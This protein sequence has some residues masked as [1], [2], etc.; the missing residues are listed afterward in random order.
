MSIESIY[1]W[2][3]NNPTTTFFILIPISMIVFAVSRSFIGK[4]LV[5][6]SER[7]ETKVDDILV[8]KLR[9]YRIAYI[10]PILLFQYNAHLLPSF[11]T[12][13]NLM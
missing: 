10:P 2:I 3:E 6:L 4:S 1:T 7:T 9:P 12:Q 8:E 13:I 11:A 5:Y